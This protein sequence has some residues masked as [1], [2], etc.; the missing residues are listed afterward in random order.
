MGRGNVPAV[1]DPGNDLVLHRCTTFRSR[2]AGWKRDTS[3]GPHEGVYLAPCRAI[4]TFGMP[5]PIDVIFLDRRLNVVRRVDAARP[6]RIMVCR[7]A[8]AVIELHAGYCRDH[9]DYMERIRRALSPCDGQ[10]VSH[11][12]GSHWARWWPVSEV[13]R[14]TRCRRC[15]TRCHPGCRVASRRKTR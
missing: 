13:F 4:H 10:A 9:P 8:H 14:A 7:F 5:C 1:H 15:R 6:N 11:G 12:R 2:L 3:P